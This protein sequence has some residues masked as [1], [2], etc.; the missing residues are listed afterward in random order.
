VARRTLEAAGYRVLDAAD[1]AEGLAL[2][3]AHAADIQ[4]VVSDIVMPRMGGPELYQAVR[5]ESP[6][7]FMLMTGYADLEI[8]SRVALDPPLPVIHKPWTGEDLLRRVRDAL[9]GR[10]PSGAGAPV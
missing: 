10:A 4:L 5:R 1:G 7:P 2:F 3:R 9:E 6:V 8:Q